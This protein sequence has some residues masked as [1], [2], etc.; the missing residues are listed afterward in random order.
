MR[1]TM[2]TISFNQA[3]YLERAMQSV[4]TQS[5][6]DIEY[7]VVDPGSTD[8]SREIIQR[9]QDRLAAVLLEADSGPAEGL[10][11]GFALASG[12]VLGYLNSDDVLLPD[13]IAGAVHAF[14]ENPSAD[15]V[16]GH[17]YVVDE[18]DVTLRPFHSRRFTL[19][20]YAYDA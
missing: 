16:Y 17:G 10:N 18:N 9:Y 20:R 13:A 12:D 2:V 19:W 1:V 5:Y 8:G 11:R 4:L 7:I 6:P 15:V 3:A 14:R